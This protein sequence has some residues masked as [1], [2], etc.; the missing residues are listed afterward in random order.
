VSGGYPRSD[1]VA[2]MRLVLRH[3]GVPMELWDT[4][5][6]REAYILEKWEGRGWWDSGVSLRAGWLTAAGREALPG[7]IAEARRRAR[8]DRPPVSTREVVGAVATLAVIT[9]AAA[10]FAI[11][12]KLA[13]AWARWTR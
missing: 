2:L 6:K 11:A 4:I 10:P 12:N 1:E 8:L 5:G 3:G 7:A 9:V 13:D